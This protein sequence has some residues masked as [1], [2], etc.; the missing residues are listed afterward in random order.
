MAKLIYSSITSLD[1]YVADE[2]GKFDWSA[3][4][5][6]VMGFLNE[7]ERPLG[8]YL[9]GRGMYEVMSGWET[10][11]ERPNQSETGRDF[12]QL[13]QAAD[14][15]VYSRTLDEVTTKR[16]RLEREFDPETVR[17]MKDSAERD[18]SVG[19]SDL[20]GQALKAGLVDEVHFYLCPIVV[21]GG[22][23]SLP[24]D[25]RLSLDL[26]EERRF[27]NGVVYVRYLTTA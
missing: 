9:Y 26:I 17:K 20:A 7:I 15:V 18:L 2:D 13:W 27:T 8:T 3:P 14:K 11:H 12:T 4:D 10:A 6:E 5:A 25:L 19:G 1:G 21:G 23:P 16:T 22:K 24:G